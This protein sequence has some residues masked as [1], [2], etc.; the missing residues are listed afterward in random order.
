[1]KGT[2]VADRDKSD[3]YVGVPNRE[4]VFKQNP[5]R[6]ADGTGHDRMGR[7]RWGMTNGPG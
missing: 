7:T 4:K 5:G 3:K 1:M 2:A 6:Y